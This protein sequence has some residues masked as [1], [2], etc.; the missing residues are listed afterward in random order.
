MV[1]TEHRLSSPGAR[2]YSLTDGGEMSFL[3]LFNGYDVPADDVSVHRA[4]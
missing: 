1:L 2:L 4:L 3:V